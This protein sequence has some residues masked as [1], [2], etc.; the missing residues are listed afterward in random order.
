MGF[1]EFVVFVVVVALIAA[2]G[3]WIVGLIPGSS[4]I[5]AK[6]I[7]GVADFIVIL[8]L[9]KVVLGGGVSDVQIPSL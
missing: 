8:V 5:F 2:V 9:L 4:P 6:V 1:I 3:V 7:V